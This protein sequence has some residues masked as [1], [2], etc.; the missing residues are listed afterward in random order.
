MNVKDKNLGEREKC[1]GTAHAHEHE[2]LRDTT[3]E[4]EQAAKR[5]TA[6]AREQE[7]E[8]KTPKLTASISHDPHAA[9]HKK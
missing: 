6:L 1:T 7:T 2:P 9:E 4:L 5:G 3:E 8:L